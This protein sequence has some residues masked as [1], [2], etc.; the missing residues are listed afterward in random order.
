MTPF[1][2][3]MA[4]LVAGA[5]LC[6]AAVPEAL[7]LNEFMASNDWVHPDNADF[8]DY[9]DWIELY[10]ATTEAIDL[11]GYF[12]TDNLSAPA[13][14]PFAAGAT[15]PAHGYLVVRAD[16]FDAAPGETHTRAFSPWAAF[17]TI[18]HHTNFK[19]SAA[20]E[21]L[22]LFRLDGSIETVALVS[23]G[24]TW[25]YLDDGSDP[26]PGW[27]QPVFDDASW[28]AGPAELGY[29][30][31]DE[32]TVVGYGS[33][34]SSKD[35]TTYFR[36]AFEVADAGVLNQCSGRLL[37]DDGAIVYLNGEE[38]FRVRMPEGAVNRETYASA[39]ATEAV[40][41]LFDLRLHAF[42]MEPIRSPS[43]FTSEAARARIS[44]L[45]WKYRRRPSTARPPSSTRWSLARSIQRFAGAGS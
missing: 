26:G 41:D 31:G 1:Y 44:A 22:G 14:W 30:D 32:A 3:L 16:G 36:H 33:N 40:F 2:K 5:G 13:K 34:S 38:V 23:L 42:K 18:R 9:S 19:L 15:I 17:T 12:L 10:N 43:K 6:G 24:A 45:I 20:G 27:A 35:P 11:E 28:S 37:A 39:V 8:D 21:E 29:G 4:S 25:R 7:R